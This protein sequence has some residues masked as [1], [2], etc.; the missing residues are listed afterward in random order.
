M[1]DYKVANMLYEGAMRLVITIVARVLVLW[2]LHIYCKRWLVDPITVCGLLYKATVQLSFK[3]TI[4]N[5]E[6]FADIYNIYT[7]IQTNSLA[8]HVLHDYL[9]HTNVF[10]NLSVYIIRYYATMFFQTIIRST[11]SIL[12]I[13]KYIQP[14]IRISF[15]NISLYTSST[16]QYT[17]VDCT[18]CSSFRK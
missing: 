7:Y 10:S 13:L 11:Y 14:H 16:V 12:N 6:F 3:L 5:L 17:Y 9:P 15:I 8:P 2:K 4:N 1:A 18:H